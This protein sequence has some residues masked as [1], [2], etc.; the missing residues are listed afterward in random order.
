MAASRSWM[1]ICRR[2]GR[3]LRSGHASAHELSDNTEIIQ[4]VH[5]RP[6][7]MIQGNLADR[8]PAP[9]RP[10]RP[11]DHLRYL[12]GIRRAEAGVGSARACYAPTAC[13]RTISCARAL[14][15]CPHDC[16]RL[17]PSATRR[18]SRLFPKPELRRPG[19][20]PP[21][22]SEGGQRWFRRRKPKRPIP[23]SR[24]LSPFPWRTSRAPSPGSRSR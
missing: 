1:T 17:R 5:S 9:A 4:A 13:L 19:R 3:C 10:C 20:F 14:A 6:E 22:R 16:F 21:R 7:P 12:R 2:S 23:I 24:R 15:K 18:G 11:R 8:E